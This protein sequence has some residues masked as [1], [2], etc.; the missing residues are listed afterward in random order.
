MRRVS[1]TPHWH[2][3]SWARGGV[4]ILFGYIVLLANRRRSF[5][6]CF[7]YLCLSIRLASNFNRFW[8]WLVQGP[9][10]YLSRFQCP[11]SLD[12]SEE[13]NCSWL[14]ELGWFALLWSIMES[15][16]SDISYLEPISGGLS[17][18]GLREPEW[19]YLVSSSGLELAV[20]V[21]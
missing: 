9:N 13:Q 7:L 18:P 8:T 20:P 21:P 2:R 4:V 16:E 5:I 12:P 1:K 15:P 3:D 19:G 11:M 17:D 14:G 6:F 10:D